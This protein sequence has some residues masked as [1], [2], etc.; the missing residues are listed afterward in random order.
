MGL[1]AGAVGRVIAAA[2]AV[3]IALAP[4]A[5][6]AEWNPPATTGRFAVPGALRPAVDF[7]KK[8]FTRYTTDE[9]VIHHAF[10]LSTIYATLDF[11]DLRGHPRAERLRKARIAAEID[12]IRRRHPGL[13]EDYVHVQY[14]IRDRFERGL[15]VSHRYLPEIER[16][17]RE[18]GLPPQLT[19]LPFIESSFN[20]NAVSK[21]G[22]SGIWQFMPSTGRIYMRVG[23]AV[24][25]RND[26][27]IAARGAARLLRHNHEV[28][29]SWPLALTAYNHGLGG[30]TRAVRVTGSR[31]IVDIIRNY[32]EASFGFASRNFYAEFLAALEV[33]RDYRRHFGDLDFDRPFSHDEIR[34]R[35][36]MFTR[37]LLSAGLSRDELESFNPAVTSAALSG[38]VPIPSGTALRVPL[39][40]GERLVAALGGIAPARV[41]EYAETGTTRHR[42]RRGETLRSVAGR[43]AVSRV[44]LAR[45]NGL[46][47]RAKLR[48]GQVLRVPVVVAVSRPVVREASAGRYDNA[49][50]VRRSNPPALLSDDTRIASAR[51]DPRISEAPPED[52]DDNEA[53]GEATAPPPP[54]AAL[55]DWQPMDGG[56]P[57]AVD[58]TG[59]LLGGAGARAATV[60]PPGPAALLAAERIEPPV[61]A[62]RATAAKDKAG[63]PALARV[64][65][66]KASAPPVPAPVLA[67]F[68]APTAAAPVSSPGATNPGSAQRGSATERP[69]R[70][71]STRSRPLSS[72]GA[73]IGAFPVRVANAEPADLEPEEPD[74][75]PRKVTARPSSPSHRMHVV[76]R[77]ES[78]WTIARRYEVPVAS[79]R[80]A[81]PDKKLQPLMPGTRLRIPGKAGNT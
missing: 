1:L 30:V 42:V 29:G 68:P 32:R 73:V 17:F 53:S 45:A 18:E 63:A 56:A 20:V 38:R 75:P 71:D 27:I 24:D 15:V 67:R 74:P 26:P 66:V 13:G 70:S 8:I 52:E 5:A 36:A 64:P 35:S 33:D 77:N 61:S 60:R 55:P 40:R 72:P 31:N 59:L 4:G 9:A 51:P 14:G 41:R 79:V 76:R 37:D 11:R 54:G 81:N 43:Y 65:V 28:T 21:V 22:A 3:L 49:V 19:R 7:W 6:R 46:S 25:E 34:L 50:L 2:L 58:A 78:L 39:G 48:R 44:A 62:E 47:T 69:T 12:R 80:R 10:D 23:T 16:I 57:R